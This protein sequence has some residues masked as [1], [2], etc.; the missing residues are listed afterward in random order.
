MA[1][2]VLGQ[3]THLDLLVMLLET[4]EAHPLPPGTR[5]ECEMSDNCFQPH[6]PEMITVNVL[7]RGGRCVG[8][9]KIKYLRCKYWKSFCA[10][11]AF[12]FNLSVYFPSL[13]GT[14]RNRTSGIL[15]KLNC[16]KQLSVRRDLLI[17]FSIQYCHIVLNMETSY[18]IL[19]VELDAL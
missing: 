17:V 3:L 18:W 7:R 14:G 5:V 12:H 9:V 19:G 2:D 10:T 4:S 15:S 8:G 11:S 6:H 1:S 16:P 13:E